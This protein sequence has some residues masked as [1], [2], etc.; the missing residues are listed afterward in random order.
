MTK[1]LIS[2]SKTSKVPPYSPTNHS[3]SLFQVLNIRNKKEKGLISFDNPNS[4]VIINRNNVKPV[5][6][7]SLETNEEIKSLSWY[8]LGYCRYDQKHKF[9]N[10]FIDFMNK[11]DES[12]ESPHISII[13]AFLPSQNVNLSE[14]FKNSLKER[15]SAHPRDKSIYIILNNHLIL[16]IHRGCF[17]QRRT[18]NWNQIKSSDLVFLDKTYI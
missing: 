11:L 17:K 4:G 3:Y 5:D 8:E 7:I 16:E 10:I 15:S 14:R 18:R 12:F 9:R 13:S 1:T 6:F 2:A